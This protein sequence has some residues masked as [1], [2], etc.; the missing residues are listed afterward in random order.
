M[1]EPGEIWGG[2]EP[3]HNAYRIDPSKIKTLDDVIR[4]I[5]ALNIM[6]DRTYPD[7]EQIAD[8]VTKVEK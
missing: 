6:V 2:A 7:F 8:L 4:I 1:S 3:D 5:D